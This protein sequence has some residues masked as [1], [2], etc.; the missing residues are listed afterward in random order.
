M[1]DTII[2]NALHWVLNGSS[3]AYLRRDFIGGDV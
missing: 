2:L 3:V 1:V